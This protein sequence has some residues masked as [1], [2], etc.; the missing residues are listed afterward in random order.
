MT[1]T[2]LRPSIA[3][4][5]RNMALDVGAFSS[6]CKKPT[7]LVL[8]HREELTWEELHAYLQPHPFKGHEAKDPHT[9]ALTTVRSVTLTQGVAMVNLTNKTSVTW[10]ALQPLLTTHPFVGTFVVPTPGSAPIEVLQARALRSGKMF[11]FT[12]DST[13]LT[14]A[15]VI[16]TNSTPSLLFSARK[17]PT[18]RTK[19]QIRKAAQLKVAARAAAKT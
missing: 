3:Y 6:S 4:S 5:I 14:E 19:Q 10:E 8:S 18:S 15:E 7:I 1:R 13:R 16:A 17:T 2:G 11:Y 12:E 9:G